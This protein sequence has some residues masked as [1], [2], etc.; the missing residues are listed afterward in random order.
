MEQV[1]IFVGSKKCWVCS[2]IHEI[3]IKELINGLQYVVYNYV[4]LFIFYIK[5]NSCL[6]TLFFDYFLYTVECFLCLLN[7]DYYSCSIGMATVC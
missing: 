5:D 7:K 2:D 6:K 4:C 3:K 1:V